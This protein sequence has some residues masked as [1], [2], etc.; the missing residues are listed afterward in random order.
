MFLGAGSA[1]TG[2]A[3]L[4]AAA[5]CKAGLSRDE[6]LSRLHFVDVHGLVVESRDDLLAHNLPYAHPGPPMGCVDALR[7]IRPHV[8]IGATGAPGTFTREVIEAMA[9]FNERPAV[10][11]LSNPTS[12]AECTAEQ[13][14]RWSG[15]RALFASGS[16]FAPV[17]YEGHVHASAQ[18]NNAYIFPGIGLGALVCSATRVSDGMFLAAADALASMVSEGHLGKGALYPPLAEI[19]DIS[20]GVAVAVA[21]QAYDEDLALAPRPADLH[22]HVRAMM[23]NPAY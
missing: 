17:A 2:I 10:F 12:R 11:A 9:E 23:Y 16:P 3:D 21:E 15:G 6:A 18:G 13:A 7:A 20:A 19:R 4:T 8:L 5:L 1:A 14:I 22:E